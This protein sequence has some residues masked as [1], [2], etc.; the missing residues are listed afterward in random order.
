MK[1]EEN[2]FSDGAW[3]KRKEDIRIYLPEKETQ[4]KYRVLAEEYRRRA[5]QIC[6]IKG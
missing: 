3:K 2:D 6:E 5:K 4:A 1:M